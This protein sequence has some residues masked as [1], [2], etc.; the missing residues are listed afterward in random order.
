MIGVEA[1]VNWR[2]MY[3][4]T[5]VGRR[6]DSRI[7]LSLTPVIFS[8]SA[9]EKNAMAA[10]ISSRGSAKRRIRPIMP[11]RCHAGIAIGTTLPAVV[12]SL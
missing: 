11:G 7:R 3:N 10:V 9:I 12:A 8:V 6:S 4:F 1:M 5:D 2:S